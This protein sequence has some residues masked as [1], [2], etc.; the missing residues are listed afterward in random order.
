[1]E[2]KTV[3]ECPQA[4]S[5]GQ[6]SE[7]LLSRRS[8]RWD[9]VESQTISWLRFP[10]AIGVVLIHA[11]GVSPLTSS[12]VENAPSLWVEC[13]KLLRSLLSQWLPAVA[14]PAFFLI[15]GRL[16]FRGVN[17]FSRKVYFSKLH[18]RWFSLAVPYLL[19]NVI[20]LIVPFLRLR[21]EVLTF[22]NAFEKFSFYFRQKGGWSVFW[23]SHSIGRDT[24]NWFGFPVEGLTAPVDVPLWFV[25]ELM[26]LALL[27]PVIGWLLRRLRWRFLLMLFLCYVLSVWM[28]VHGLS[29]SAALFFSLGAWV[30]L[31]GRNLVELCRPCYRIS[32]LLVVGMLI[33]DRFFQMPSPFSAGWQLLF[34]VAEI[35]LCV[36]V[37]ASL[38]AR[39]RWRFPVVL[40]GSVF[41]IYAAHTV[42][43]LGACDRWW[44]HCWVVDTPGWLTLRYCVVVLSA[45]VCCVLLNEMLRRLCPCLHKLLSGKR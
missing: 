17:H 10:L 21:W 43:I 28:P 24:H 16:F 19:W 20:A 9:S 32:A 13:C 44:R 3:S 15:S 6:H 33:A 2:E 39:R 11:Y 35:V 14:V 7:C 38:S 26:V 27:S 42:E 40:S 25:R 18:R 30:S 41:V 37:A 22:D 31:T 8:H 4:E 5:T 12:V 45:V 36:N 1:M 29:V 34:I 23:D